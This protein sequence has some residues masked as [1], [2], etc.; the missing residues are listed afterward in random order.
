MP[1]KPGDGALKWTEEDYEKIKTLA[2]YGMKPDDIA[3]IFG[4]SGRT[5]RKYMAENPDLK[6]AMKAG[7]ANAD[8][9]VIQALKEI[10]AGLTP[11]TIS[12]EDITAFLFSEGS[13]AKIG[14][15]EERFKEFLREKCKGQA[16]DKVRI[17]LK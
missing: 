4:R 16:L 5:L 13:S 7:K 9:N 17:V 3:A 11:I 8:A 2:S 6:A 12:G 10:L 15:L 1:K 14:D